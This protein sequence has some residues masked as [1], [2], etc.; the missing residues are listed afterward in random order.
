MMK[1]VNMYTYKDLK[2]KVIRML[3]EA[4][5][6]SN[7]T[8]IATSSI[9]DYLIAMPDL[10]N[11]ALT[12]LLPAK[13]FKVKKV[14]IVQNGTDTGIVKKY[15]LTTLA[16]DFYSLKDREIYFEDTDS[17]GLAS[18]YTIENDNIFKV[19]PSIVGT[20]TI[21]YNAYPQK[22][23]SPTDSTEIDVYPEV[24]ELLP[25]HICGELLF[26]N[27]EDGG[28]ER[29]SEFEQRREE[30]IMQDNKKTVVTVKYDEIRAALL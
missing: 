14:T 6:T 29:K 16:S 10:L 1:G 7:D 22:I 12:L 21:Y 25:F 27:D 28:I 30:L 9:N 15:D 2:L 26:S 23:E 11:Q 19:D 20:W 3:G 13:R 4:R 8:V 17:Y 24:F 5:N 18:N